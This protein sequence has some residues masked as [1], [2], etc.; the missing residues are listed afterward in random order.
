MNVGAYDI[1]DAGLYFSWG[2]IEGISADDEAAVAAMTEA[3]YANTHGATINRDLLAGVDDPSTAALGIDWVTPSLEDIQELIEECN[4][5]LVTVHGVIGYRITSKAEGNSNTIFIPCGGY[6]N[7]GVLHNTTDNG[8][9]WSSTYKE[10]RT[11]WC[12]FFSQES[13]YNAQAIGRWSGIN[14]RAVHT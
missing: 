10:Q 11:S 7:E 4:W 3:E 5:A 9:L 14:V 6:I 1:W 2:N 12:L 8:F 13:Q